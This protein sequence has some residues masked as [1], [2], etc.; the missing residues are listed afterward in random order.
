M[1]YGIKYSCD[2]RAALFR[3]GYRRILLESAAGSEDKQDGGRT[4]VA[5]GIG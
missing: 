5:Q 3:A 1:T 4:R 2:D